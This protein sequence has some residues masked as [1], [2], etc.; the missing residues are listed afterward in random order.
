VQVKIPAVG[1]DVQV[2]EI[3]LLQAVQ[4]SGNG[5]FYYSW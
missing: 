3:V 4:Q 2:A 5:F 1:D